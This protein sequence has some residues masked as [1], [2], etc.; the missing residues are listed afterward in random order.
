MKKIIIISILIIFLITAFSPIIS[1]GL[2]INTKTTESNDDI[3]KLDGVDLTVEY[4]YGWWSPAPWFDNMDYAASAFCL[5][6]NGDY[7]EGVCNIT[8]KVYKIYSNLSENETDVRYSNKDYIPQGSF[9]SFHYDCWVD[10]EQPVFWRIEITSNIEETNYENNV[11]TIPNQLGVTIDG[12]VY[13]EDVSGN[14]NPVKC[15]LI[16][17]NSDMNNQ[18]FYY[19]TDSKGYYCIKI[20]KNPELG[21]FKYTISATI[22]GIEPKEKIQLTEPLDGFEYTQN[23][24]TFKAKSRNVIR[25]FFNLFESFFQRF[26]FIK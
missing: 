18:E 24:F 7:F 22:L 5:R 4:F 1:V 21:P 14:K 10:S 23:N 19:V 20:P 11:I 2:T 9:N 17:S 16:K 12:Y 13:K 8:T 6:N 15:A 25:N 3:Q 26:S